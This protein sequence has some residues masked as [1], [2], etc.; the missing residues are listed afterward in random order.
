MIGTGYFK[1]FYTQEFLEELLR[2]TKP[3]TKINNIVPF[4]KYVADDWI[5]Q[6]NTVYFCQI[7]N[8]ITPIQMYL[9]G[10]LHPIVEQDRSGFVLFDNITNQFNA[11]FTGWQITLE[12]TPSDIYSGAVPPAVNQTAQI[13]NLKYWY[14]INN[15]N[16][17][18]AP[19]IAFS[20]DMVCTVP[21]YSYTMRKG[22]TQL[23]G[24]STFTGNTHIEGV[25]TFAFSPADVLSLNIHQANPAVEGN[26]LEKKII[27]RSLEIKPYNII[28]LAGHRI[29]LSI[30]Q[31]CTLEAKQYSSDNTLLQTITNNYVTDDATAIIFSSSLG[32][33]FEI[34][35][36]LPFPSVFSFVHTV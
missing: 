18:N 33:K 26:I 16:T 32:T 29:N 13:N 4:T 14:S 19:S 10:K 15:N 12:N 20:M 21:L 11:V 35:I 27:D 31:P 5:N 9:N 30:L 1:D 36:T 24:S 6:A 25:Q 22:I 3:G 2:L 8:G 28:L 17:N 7:H 23:I 34:K